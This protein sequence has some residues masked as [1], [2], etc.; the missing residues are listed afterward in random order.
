M[1]DLFGYFRLERGVL[2]STKP[3][4]W[5]PD[6]KLRMFANKILLLNP[7]YFILNSYKILKLRANVAIVRW[8]GHL[9]ACWGDFLP[10]QQ[11]FLKFGWLDDQLQ[12]RQNYTFLGLGN[13]DN[14]IMKDSR[15]IWSGHM[16]DPRLMITE[17]DALVIQFTAYISDRRRNPHTHQAG[18][19]GRINSTTNRVEFGVPYLLSLK[20]KEVVRHEKNWVLFQYNSTVH[21]IYSYHPSVVL[22]IQQLHTES[23]IAWVADE[24]AWKFVEDPS[25]FSLPYHTPT[26]GEVRGGT[27]ALLVK[28]NNESFYFAIFHSVRHNHFLRQHGNYFMGAITF[29]PRPPFQIRSISRFPIIDEGFSLYQGAWA[30]NHLDYIVFPTGIVFEPSMNYFLLSLGHQDQDVVFFNIS[31]TEILK[32]L[33]TVHI[34]REV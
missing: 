26:F 22:T 16:E 3:I 32:T 19:V 17:D 23:D 15:A 2:P 20:G 33:E 6:D 5:S 31:F 34:C 25:T 7:P 9:L 10:G 27:P 12:I 11:R 29:C 4:D 18:I 1:S 14:I 21:F 24:P 30:S 8:H 13:N 28:K